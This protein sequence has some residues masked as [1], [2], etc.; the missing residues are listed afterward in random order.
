MDITRFESDGRIRLAVLHDDITERKRSEETLKL[1]ELRLNSLLDLF[2]RSSDLAETEQILNDFCQD[3]QR[4][5]LV[6]IGNQADVNAG[7]CFEFFISAGLAEG[8]TDQDIESVVASAESSRKPI[9]RF[10]C[11]KRGPV[12][13]ITVRL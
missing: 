6:E 2:Q 12:Q 13:S 4:Q 8:K 10:Q 7:S 3:L 1:N 11:E 5:G 9:A